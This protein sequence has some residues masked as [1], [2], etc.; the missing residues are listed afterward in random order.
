MFRARGRWGIPAGQHVR[1]VP[2]FMTPGGPE[3]GLQGLAAFLKATKV[4]AT[5]LG[6][7]VAHGTDF[8]N[9]GIFHHHSSPSRF[10]G[11]T[12]VVSMYTVRTAYSLGAWQFL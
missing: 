4:V 2:N 3:F 10:S 7:G 1:G 5:F 8:R 9:Q 6:N 11:V 12:I